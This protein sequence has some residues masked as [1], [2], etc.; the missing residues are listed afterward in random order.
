[1]FSLTL[2]WIRTSF[3][4]PLHLPLIS[5]PL[6]WHRLPWHSFP[7]SPYSRAVSPFSTNV[8]CLFNSYT[9]TSQYGRGP[10]DYI[11]HSLSL[12][13]P[14]LVLHTTCIVIQSLP[15]DLSLDSSLTGFLSLHHYPKE[16]PAL[17]HVLALHLSVCYQRLDYAAHITE[18]AEFNE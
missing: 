16:T 1:M 17:L 9:P 8:L 4:D 12:L 3:S 6:T 2:Q 7:T 5:Y 10:M 11:S 15:L 13:S 18:V 14:Q